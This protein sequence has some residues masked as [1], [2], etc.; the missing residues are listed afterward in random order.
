MPGFRARSVPRTGPAA[1]AIGRAQAL[2]HCIRFI[3]CALPA[4]A[5]LHRQRP[6]EHDRV[7]S[8]IGVRPRN[9]PLDE[10]RPCKCKHERDEQQNA[11]RQQ[12]PIAQRALRRSLRLA[13]LDEHQRRER[14]LR[15]ICARDTVQPDRNA[16]REQAEQE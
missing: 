15:G 13:G 9:G 16:D 1:D 4:I 7:Q 10:Q 11:Q 6:V 14:M 5:I 12:Q 8:R 3:E 2:Q